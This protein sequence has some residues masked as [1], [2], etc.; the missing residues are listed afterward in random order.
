[1]EEVK[2]PGQRLCSSQGRNV[3]RGENATNA[4]FKL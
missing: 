2:P 4:S 1:M 3:Y